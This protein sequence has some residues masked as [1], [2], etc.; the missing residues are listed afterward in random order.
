MIGPFAP[1]PV[2]MAAENV[3]RMRRTARP[4]PGCAAQIGQRRRLT[5]DAIYVPALFCFVNPENARR[6]TEPHIA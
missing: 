4:N 3:D 1:A 2:M 6:R 5:L